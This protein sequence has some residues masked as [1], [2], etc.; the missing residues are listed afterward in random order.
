M[1]PKDA[2]KNVAVRA[3]ASVPRILRLRSVRRRK[4]SDFRIRSLGEEVGNLPNLITLS[5]L[6]L[7]P[8]ILVFLDRGTPLSH[9]IASVLFI[10]AG[11]SDFLD[12]WLARRTGKITLLGKFLDPLADKLTTLSVM[13]TLVGMDLIPAWLLILMLFREFA[14][15]GLRALAMGEGVVIAA[16]ESG[17]Q[18][19]AFQFF[20]LTFLLVYFPYPLL[21]TGWMLDFHRM[22]LFILYLSL[23]L[24]LFSAVEYFA[25]FMEAVEQ[26][27]LQRSRTLQEA[28]REA[29]LLVEMQSNPSLPVIEE[30]E[31]QVALDGDAPSAD[32]RP[33]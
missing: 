4:V 32:E 21:G 5:R 23:I 3:L 15:T 6:V 8:V 14:V 18:K 24:S 17:K 7:I 20:G 9:Y 31:M 19:T 27:N 12:G 28:A 1:K 33:E 26:K 25:L 22:G 16:S 30:I 11:F 13:V 2:P 10:F 29:G